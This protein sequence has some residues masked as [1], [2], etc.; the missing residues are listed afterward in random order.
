MKH[1]QIILQSRIKLLTNE[2][3]SNYSPTTS[4]Q[5]THQQNRIKSLICE[6]GSNYSSKQE[7]TI[8]EKLDMCFSSSDRWFVHGQNSDPSRK[9]SGQITYCEARSNYS[10]VKR[11]DLTK[12]L[13]MCFSLSSFSWTAISCKSEWF[14][15]ASQYPFTD[16]D[17]KSGLFLE[18]HFLFW[19]VLWPGFAPFTIHNSQ[20]TIHNSQFTT[21]NSQLTIHNSQFTMGLSYFSL[22]LWMK[23][24]RR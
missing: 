18:Y 23:S 12:K 5:I 15:P 9:L 16:T 11:L 20:F 2:V 1:D 6:A 4:N 22:K 21:H 3:G 7:M 14:D 13:D 19:W 8:Q 17:R 10:L 24:E